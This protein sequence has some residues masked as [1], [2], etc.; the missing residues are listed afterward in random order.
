MLRASVAGPLISGSGSGCFSVAGLYSSSSSSS[1]SSF[2][3]S[4]AYTT[5][6]DVRPPAFLWRPT[7]TSSPP[8][9]KAVRLDPFSGFA[10]TRQLRRSPELRIRLTEAP[11]SSSP[12]PSSSCS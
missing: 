1:G 8:S 2:A 6:S 4:L 11:S 9:S 3:S 5:A 10:P 12:S 7:R